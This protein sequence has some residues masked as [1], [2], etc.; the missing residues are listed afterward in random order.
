[1]ERGPIHYLFVLCGKAILFFLFEQYKEI[2]YLLQFLDSVPGGCQYCLVFPIGTWESEIPGLVPSFSAPYVTFGGHGTTFKSQFIFLRNW[3]PLKTQF[4]CP[5][6]WALLSLPRRKPI[7]KVVGK[8]LQQAKGLN[9]SSSVFQRTY[10]PLFQ[11]LLCCLAPRR[12][13]T[14]CMGYSITAQ[15]IN[16]KNSTRM[17]GLNWGWP[18]VY[19]RIG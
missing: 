17:G 5:I 15:F 2:T 13:C 4:I 7:L 10:G 11:R 14:N 3:V 9:W 1:M 16:C 6:N 18:Y 12:F 8:E 19:L